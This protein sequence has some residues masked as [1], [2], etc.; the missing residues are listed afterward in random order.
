MNDEPKPALLDVVE[1]M[2]QSVDRVV[3][4]CDTM[5]DRMA[6]IEKRMKEIDDGN[7]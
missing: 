1:K 4:L 6:A 5:L 2:M 3:A 7:K